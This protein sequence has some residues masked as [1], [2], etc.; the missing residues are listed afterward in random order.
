[1]CI[2][3]RVNDLPAGADRLI[4]HPRGIQAV[5]VNGRPLPPPGQVPDRPSGQLLRQRRQA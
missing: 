4:A 2:R 3:D 1:M 5:I